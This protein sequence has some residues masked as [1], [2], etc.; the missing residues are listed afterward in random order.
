MFPVKE[1]NDG[2]Y[3][4]L[5]KFCNGKPDC[6]DGSDELTIVDNEVYYDARSDCV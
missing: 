6:Q 5:Y 2:S 3:L 4:E 1:C